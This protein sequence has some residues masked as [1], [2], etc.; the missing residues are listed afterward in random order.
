MPGRCQRRIVSS[1]ALALLCVLPAVSARNVPRS[2]P[3]GGLPPIV[4]GVSTAQSG[5]AGEAG[6]QLITGSQ[7][8]FDIV[9]QA[10]G[11]NG[12]KI[13]M[14]VKDD[15]YDPDLAVQNA[16]E[17]ITKDQ[18]FALFD[19]M[20]TPTLT[21][22]LP[23]LEYF[24][25]EHIVTFAPFTGSEPPRRSPYD[26]YAFNVRAS[27][28]EETE[29]LVE[30]FY[31]KGSRRFGLFMQADSLGVSGESGVR[32]ALA[33]RGLPL[34]DTVTYRRNS[35]FQTDM[36]EQVKLLRAKNVDAVIAMSIYEPGSRFI[37]DARGA[38]WNVPI[39]IL[40]SEAATQVLGRASGAG[41][42]LSIENVIN[43]QVVPSP[44]DTRYPLVRQY[45]AH[46]LESQY[47]PKSLEGWL[48]AVVLTEGLRRAG[49]NPSRLDFIRAMEHLRGWNPGLG[50]DFNFSVEDHQGLHTVWLSKLENGQWVAIASPPQ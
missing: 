1:V 39:G 48:N 40:D 2:V 10:G 21:R 45:R 8:Y 4:L 19:S 13:T 42:F 9:N 12:R 47:S 35:T 20:G 26:R 3:T 31:S 37:R 16:Y 50:V 36:S 49:A 24:Q 18:V 32:Q 22:V 5:V 6:K 33:A 14:L 27:F 17:L 25:A 34:I 30:Y 11:I 43:C 28:S 38:G 41:N 29:R 44:D 23:L 46:I 15:R 7:A